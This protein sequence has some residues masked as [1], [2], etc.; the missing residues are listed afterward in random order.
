MR[1]APAEDP[2]AAAMRLMCDE[3]ALSL[4]QIEAPSGEEKPS[5]AG[6][7]VQDESG[8]E[9]ASQAPLADKPEREADPSDPVNHRLVD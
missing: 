2:L 3:E 8:E 1:S 7:A 4:E 9:P 6:P 5:E